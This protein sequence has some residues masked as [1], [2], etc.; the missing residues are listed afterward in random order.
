MVFLDCGWTQSH[1]FFV[2]MG[3]FML[4]EGGKATQTLTADQLESLSCEDKIDFPKITET[5][6]QDRSKGDGLTKGLVIVHT[7]WFIIQCIARG[8]KH[9]PVTTFEL[10]TLAFA[11]INF[12]TYGLWWHKP[13]N[14]RCAV[15]VLAKGNLGNGGEGEREENKQGS[16]QCV[17]I[18][19]PWC[20]TMVDVV[21]GFAEIF[22]HIP[23]GGNTK[24]KSRRVPTF[25]WGE[26]SDD[27]WRTY[28][29]TGLVG[30]IFGAIHCIAW[31]SQFPSPMEQVLWRISAI[32]IIGVPV[33]VFLAGLLSL[34]LPF[35]PNK[36]EGCGGV[37][38]LIS[39][40]LYVIARIMLFFLAL[41]SLR[42]LPAGAFQ[43]INWTTYI[44][45]IQ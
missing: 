7:S 43:V 4:F 11:V 40:V 6:I 33:C 1:G 19:R 35:L 2:V 38:V 34:Y 13:L 29:V 14:V 10:M 23:G 30:V 9:L 3:G 32:T 17:P 12:A 8:V 24:P 39:A 5:E 37:L 27:D 15:H 36:H 45:H 22:G 21:F 16:G 44:P 26:S 31:S 18:R 20:R 41:I 25:H 42:S 28:L